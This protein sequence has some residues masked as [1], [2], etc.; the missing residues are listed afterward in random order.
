MESARDEIN[1][2]FEERESKKKLSEEEIEKIQELF[3]TGIDACEL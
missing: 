3:Q 1:D 2:F